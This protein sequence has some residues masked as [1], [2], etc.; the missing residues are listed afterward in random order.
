MRMILSHRSSDGTIRDGLSGRRR[1]G[2]LILITLLPRLWL[3]HEFDVELSNDGFDAI[4]TLVIARSEGL[5]AVPRS[6]V[7]RF[8]LHPLYMALLFALRLLTPPAVDFYVVARLFST[9]MACAAVL[10]MFRLVRHAFGE[11]SAWYASVLLAF[12]PT[13]LW[14]SAAIISSTL[15][16]ILYLSVVYALALQRYRLAACLAFFSALTRYEGVVLLGL[17]LLA[18]SVRDAH[19]RRLD[20]KTWLVCLGLAVCAPLVI[21]GASWVMVGNP[22]GFFGAQ[23][24]AGIWLRVIAPG[25]SVQRGAFFVTRYADLLPL[26]VVVLGAAGIVLALWRHRKRPLWLLLALLA[27]YLL[28]FEVLVLLDYTT[29]EVRFLMYP[30]L[31]LLVLAGVVLSEAWEWL[32]RLVAQ[33]PFSEVVIGGVLAVLVVM[34]YRQGT[35]GMRWTYNG[36]ASQREVVDQLLEFIPPKRPTNVLVY[37]GTA[38]ALDYFAR[39]ENLD[40]SL[41]WFRFASEDE[42][43]QFLLDEGISFLIYPANNPFAESKYPYLAQAG[44]QTRGP[45]K[46]EP[47]TQFETSLDHQAY[48]IWGASAK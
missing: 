8:V 22:L 31:P 38:G 30:G 17:V 19:S 4:K 43:E 34:S 12:A 23:S 27:L 33:K 16:L 6:L 14:E 32:L 3:L 2:L 24:M 25:T 44:A 21:L 48:V 47:L 42:P 28:F 18:L 11:R 10:V 26:P 1:C 39:Q 37:G 35:A 7:E 15:F 5:A 41:Y 40:L 36:Y 45:V 20:I 29:L 13:F 46:F 9:A